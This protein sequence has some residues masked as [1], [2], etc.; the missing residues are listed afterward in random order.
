MIYTALGDS[1]TFGK[2]ASSWQRAYPQRILSALHSSSHKACGHV[3]ARPGWSSHE[4]LHALRQEPL[5]LRGSTSVS[6]W[7][8]GVDLAN[9]AL[10]IL[11]SQRLLTVE[12]IL[13]SYKR[14]LTSII[15]LIKKFGSPRIVC[16]TQYNPFPNSPVAAEGI[17][18]LNRMTNKLAQTFG[19][20]VAPVHAWFEG[21]Q[22]EMI[23]GYREG[24]IEDALGGFLPIHPNDHG[25]RVIASELAPYF[26]TRDST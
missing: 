18:Q 1:I 11:K 6:I 24:K 3:F 5:V 25:H 13:G 16:C 21:K 4:L 12:R 2:D 23:H 14:N 20:I 26:A 9:G 7:I 17:H 10:S 22:A 19:I 8:G 15:K